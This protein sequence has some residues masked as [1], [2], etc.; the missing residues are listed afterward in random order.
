MKK[1]EQKLA[2]PQRIPCTPGSLEDFVLN[3]APL[4]A[5]T[6]EFA[7]FLVAMFHEEGG[8]GSHKNN[9]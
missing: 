2:G 6:P 8:E 5:D 4:D 7:D 9:H 1:Q 3:R